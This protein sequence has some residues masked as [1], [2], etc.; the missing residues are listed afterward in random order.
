MFAVQWAYHGWMNLAP[1]AGEIARPQRNIPLALLG[2]IAVIIFL[3]LGESGVLSGAA[4][5]RTEVGG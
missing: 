3:Y 1:V 4:A 5:K 2:G